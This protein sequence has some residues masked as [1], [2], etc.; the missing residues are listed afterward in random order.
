M[1]IAVKTPLMAAE[2][3]ELLD[4]NTFDGITFKFLEKKGMENI[5]EVSG[6]AAEITDAVAIA[7]NVIKSTS[8][9]KGLYFSV[10]EK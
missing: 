2:I 5:F 10:V 3:K 6:D 7:K 4:G 1:C 8:F 9:G